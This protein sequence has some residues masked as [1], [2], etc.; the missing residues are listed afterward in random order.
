MLLKSQDVS[1]CQLVRQFGTIS[2]IV[3]GVNYQGNLF[4]RG[5]SYPHQQRQVAIAEMRRSYLDPEP[6]VACLL[7]ADGEIETI[8]YEDRYILK[9]VEDANDIVTYFNLAQLVEEMRSPQGVKIENRSQS[10]RL[11]YLRCAIGREMVDWMS[12]KLSISRPHAVQLGQRSIDENWLRNLSNKQPFGD[13][14]LYYQFCMD[15]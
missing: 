9:I 12:T 5:N 4:V 10:F 2:E 15:K 11:P 6:A 7:V 14:D 1:Y 3:S 8:W 13:N